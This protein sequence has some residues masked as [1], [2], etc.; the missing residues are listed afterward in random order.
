[1]SLQFL[2]GILLAASLLWS[3]TPRTENQGQN[4]GTGQNTGQGRNRTST[5]TNRRETVPTRPS[6]LTV[7][8]GNP[9]DTTRTAIPSIGGNQV[10][11][12]EFLPFTNYRVGPEDMIAVIVLDAP[13]F[14]RSVRINAEGGL[15]LPL[16]KQMIP[17]S[18]KTTAELEQTIARVLVEEG[19]LREPSVSVTVR[20]FQSKPV[21]VTGAVRA[22]MVFQAL[23][24][25][26][27]S[28]ALA[29]AGG[30][31][32]AAGPD[33]LITIPSSDGKAARKEVRVSAHNLLQAGDP[34]A[35][36][37]LNGGEEVRV[38]PAGRVYIIGAITR[39]GPVLLS[40]D[41]PLS[42]LQAVSLAGGP[43]LYAGKKAYLLRGS[44]TDPQRQ[45]IPFDFKTV[46]KR[47]ENNLVLQANDV[48][49]V[50]DSQFKRATQGGVSAAATSLMYSLGGVLL[51]R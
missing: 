11:E 2:L 26:P 4:Q 10:R 20:E 33:I 21:T 31:S 5:E 15:R 37:I 34:D 28:E 18:G 38:M 12:E 41:R 6:T 24:P 16:V 36:L 49:F 45:E 1:M 25:L 13:E 29:R 46:M 7:E 19:L 50:P 39:P 35:N 44:E 48:I 47:P 17:A 9:F 30:V 23:R 3:Q 43:T 14:S 42:L 51:W 32:D 27:L 8:P 40:D 22:P